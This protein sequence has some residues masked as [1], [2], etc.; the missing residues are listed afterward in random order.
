M[1]EATFIFLQMLLPFLAE[2]V[3][4]TSVYKGT[5]CFYNNRT[6]ILWR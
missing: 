2:L 4:L 5:A 1:L 3:L 6:R